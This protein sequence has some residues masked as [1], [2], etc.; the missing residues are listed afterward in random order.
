[1]GT[2]YKEGMTNLYETYH[3]IFVSVK[4]SE[5][6]PKPCMIWEVWWFSLFPADRWYVSWGTFRIRGLRDQKKRELPMG[7]GRSDSPG[8]N[9]LVAHNFAQIRQLA[10]AQGGADQGSRWGMT[11]SHSPIDMFISN[12]Y[13]YIYIY[14]KHLFASF[15]SHNRNGM[16]QIWTSTH[17]P[18]IGL[19]GMIFSSGSAGQ[20]L[21]RETTCGSLMWA[22]VNT[23]G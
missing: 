10:R 6:R 16:V 15:L 23:H 8:V 3:L 17:T 9:G 7:R 14:A 18:W 5:S 4:V 13:T 22:M 19:W 12:C 20:S 2:L 21:F 11:V 1:M